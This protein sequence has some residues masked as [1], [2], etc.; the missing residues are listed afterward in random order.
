MHIFHEQPLSNISEEMSTFGFSMY[1]SSN[2]LHRFCYNNLS[3]SVMIPHPACSFYDCESRSIHCAL[4]TSST[5]VVT[6]PQPLFIELSHRGSTGL[7]LDHEQGTVAGCIRLPDIL[8]LSL[9]RDKQ[10]LGWATLPSM[11]RL[12]QQ[13]DS[14]W[15][16]LILA[17]QQQHLRWLNLCFSSS[18]PPK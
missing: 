1:T 7:M 3:F 14:L 18:P 11:S 9:H 6:F 15:V 2:R 12:L 13:P 16:T 17:R 5:P 4:P 8:W 10:G